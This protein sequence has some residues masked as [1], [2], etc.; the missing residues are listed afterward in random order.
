MAIIIEMASVVSLLI[1]YTI[2][3]QKTLTLVQMYFLYECANLVPTV[4]TT[5][6]AQMS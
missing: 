2:K 3:V 1:I 5:I 6:L 4:K